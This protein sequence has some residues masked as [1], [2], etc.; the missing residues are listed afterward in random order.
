M[1]WVL[2]IANRQT[3]SDQLLH[4]HHQLDSYGATPST[5]PADSHSLEDCYNR[6]AEEYYSVFAGSDG[7]RDTTVSGGMYMN[8]WVQIYALA[9]LGPCLEACSLYYSHETP[10]TSS[11]PP[12]NPGDPGPAV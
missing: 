11:G 10:T 7:T 6:C 1:P 4:V 8:V 3:L 9:R 5:N 2:A 12:T